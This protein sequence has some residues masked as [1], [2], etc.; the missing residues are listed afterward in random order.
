VDIVEP[1]IEKNQKTYTTSTIHFQK[2]N[3]L[4]EPPELADLWIVRDF[5]CLYDY[6]SCKLLFDKF[7]ESNSTYIAL[8]TID[9]TEQNCDG[10]IGIWRQLNL[11]S[12]PF[13]LQ[14]P[15]QSISDGLQWFR[16]KWLNVYT[17]DQILESPFF[18]NPIVQQIEVPVPT[19]V[20]D[21]NVMGSDVKSIPL[22]QQHV[23]LRTK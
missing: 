5:C 22:R 13:F 6:A 3:V 7:I 19:P 18:Q 9:T 16:P 8:T 2:M 17:R 20:I 12:S 10:I 1:L 14:T 11:A 21:P 15:V 4:Q 23:R